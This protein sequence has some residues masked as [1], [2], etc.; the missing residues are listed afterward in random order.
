MCRHLVTPTGAK[1]AYDVADLAEYAAVRDAELVPV[2]ST[3]GRERILR[4]VG[5]DGDGAERY[6]IFHDVLGSAVLEWRGRHDVERE[7]LAARRRQRRSLA[8]I[9]ACLVAL[10]AMTAVAVYA[11]SERS[12][13]RTQA[14]R[15]EEQ[16]ARAERARH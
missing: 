13:A 3:L 6:E 15:A 7:R 2:L 10:A 1:I 12:A 14:A 4:P 5:G 11:L 16:K 9:A 8:V